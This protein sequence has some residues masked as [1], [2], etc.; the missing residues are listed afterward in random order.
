MNIYNR[1][2]ENNSKINWKLIA[3]CIMIVSA[4]YLY[5]NP[6]IISILLAPSKEVT[7]IAG[8]SLKQVNSINQYREIYDNITKCNNILNEIM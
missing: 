8:N 3:V 1:K 6:K 2:E 7:Q 4:V 5:F